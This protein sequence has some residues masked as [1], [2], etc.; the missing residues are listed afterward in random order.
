M[1]FA[2][3][4]KVNTMCTG[5]GVDHVPFAHVFKQFRC[6]LILG[7]VIKYIWLKHCR[8]QNG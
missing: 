3:S 8:V 5:A 1:I 4:L 2:G 6:Q 7:S